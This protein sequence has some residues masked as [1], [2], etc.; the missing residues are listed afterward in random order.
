[1]EG[2]QAAN[3]PRL[4]QKPS[5]AAKSLLCAERVTPLSEI[6]G[7]WRDECERGD[8]SSA[9]RKIVEWRPKAEALQCWQGLRFRYQNDFLVDAGESAHSLPLSHRLVR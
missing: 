4:K 9:A 3:A 2:D 1:M 8:G 7:S 5:E 6:N